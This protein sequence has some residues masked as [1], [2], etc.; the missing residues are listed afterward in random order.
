VVTDRGCY[1]K[2]SENLGRHYEIILFHAVALVRLVARAQEETRVLRLSGRPFKRFLPGLA[3]SGVK[4]LRVADRYNAVSAARITCLEGVDR[5]PISPVAHPVGVFGI[6][7]KSGYS[8]LVAVIDRRT[9]AG[10]AG[11][12]SRALRHYIVGNIS[13]FRQL[14]YH[15]FGRSLLGQPREI[16]H[17][18]VG[19]GG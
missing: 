3:F 6:R 5:T 19:S 2:T 12:L 15:V 11:E 17:R 1:G 16:H 10:F 7:R 9:G 13:L 8:G 14:D 4:Q 18:R